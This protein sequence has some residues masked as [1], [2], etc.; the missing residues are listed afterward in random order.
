MK[1]A[2]SAVA[3]SLGLGL[4]ALP[5]PSQ[6]QAQPGGAAQASREPDVIYVPTPQEVVDAMLEIAKVGPDDVL[7][8]LGSGDGRIPITAAKRHG[9][10]GV[11]IDIDPTRIRE[12]RANAEQQGVSD[13][14]TF[15]EGD[16]FEQDL[17]KATV[18]SL[19]LLPTLNLRL[20]PTLLKLKPGTR[21][22]SHAFD[23]GDWAPDQ[24]LIVNQKR[25]YFWTVPKR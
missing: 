13:K 9:T 12:A 3:V 15:I 23:M 6:A 22:V 1:H 2:L 18:I 19:Y 5:P 20:R 10:R 21:I 4:V 16:L 8:D 24:T 7:Y 11:G 14:V 17:S 25:I